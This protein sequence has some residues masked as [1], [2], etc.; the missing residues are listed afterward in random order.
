MTTSVR[1]RFAPSPTGFIHLGNIRSAL[2]PWAFARQMSGDLHAAHRGHRRRAFAPAK[3]STPL[4]KAWRGSASISTKARSTRCSGWT[5]TAKCVAQMLDAGLG[6]PLLH[7]AG[8]TRRAARAPARGRRKAALRRHLASGAGQGAAGAAGRRAA[9]GAL[10]ESAR[11]RGDMGR[12]RQRPHRDLERGTRRP[13]DRASGRHAD[14]QLLRGGRRSG[15]CAS[16]T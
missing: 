2:Y 1:T 7:V 11:R 4:S 12:R 6:L 8:R 5:V 15:T 3:R 10:Q 9:G 13:R 16:R 14:L